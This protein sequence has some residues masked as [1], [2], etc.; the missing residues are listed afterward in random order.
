MIEI[1]IYN[2]HTNE[3]L[4]KSFIDEAEAEEYEYPLIFIGAHY[5]WYKDGELIYEQE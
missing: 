4:I 5:A 2:D 1:R 3:I